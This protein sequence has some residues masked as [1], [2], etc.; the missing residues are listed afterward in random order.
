MIDTHTQTQTRSDLDRN[1][2]LVSPAKRGLAFCRTSSLFFFAFVLFQWDGWDA[3][4]D[5]TKHHRKAWF[6]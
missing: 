5:A 3:F 4:R 1:G 2:W 6:Y